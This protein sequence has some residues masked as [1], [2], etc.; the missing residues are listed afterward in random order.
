MK[1]LR[2]LLRFLLIPG[3][4]L[5]FLSSGLSILSI[6]VELTGVLLAG[7]AFCT[8]SYKPARWLTKRT[9]LK[10]FVP[11]WLKNEWKVLSVLLG[12]IFLIGVLE[13]AEKIPTLSFIFGELLGFIVLFR[14]FHYYLKKKGVPANGKSIL[15]N[16]SFWYLSISVAL[17]L[18]VLIADDL[19]K[20]A[21]ALA[22]AYFFVL[23]ILTIGWVIRQFQELVKLKNEKSKTELMHLKSQVNPHF[24]FN[25][26][27]NLYGWVGKDPKTAQNLI[28]KLSDMMRYSIYEG[29]A[30]FVKLEEE[31][32]YLK[33][34][35]SLHKMRYHKTIDVR[36]NMD[37][38]GEKHRLMPLLFIILVENAFKH[39]VE[40]LRENA[41]IDIDLSTRGDTIYFSVE[42][43]FDDLELPSGAGIG[44]KNLK[45]RLELAYPKSHRLSFNIKGDI[46]QAKLSLTTT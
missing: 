23:V 32:A 21:M 26:L 7:L 28:L 29:Q 46:Y 41:F 30:D 42:N 43:N 13:S 38:E 12:V 35:I 2:K 37:F 5:L 40:A 17:L 22:L 33:N 20:E 34:Y 15:Y 45:R 6:G 44:L 39:G 19:E 10:R 14:F 24:F 25:M 4:A 36:F 1:R 11:N 3:L 18:L 9:P 16:Y 27:N 31:V 8:I